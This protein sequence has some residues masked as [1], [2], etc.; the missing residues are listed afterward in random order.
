MGSMGVSVFEVGVQS[1]W[2]EL[3]GQ[4]KLGSSGA[5]SALFCG[6]GVL[7]VSLNKGKWMQMGVHRMTN[8]QLNNM[9]N[10]GKSTCFL[11]ISRLYTQ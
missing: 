4:K 3:L 5:F 1:L 11:N 7:W 10:I 9:V 2:I 6:F 8:R